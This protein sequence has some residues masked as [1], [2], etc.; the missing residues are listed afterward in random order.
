MR[1]PCACAP[2][3][4]LVSPAA[5]LP[6]SRAPILSECASFAPEHPS[7]R[8]TESSNSR[9][10]PRLFPRIPRLVCA[11]EFYLVEARMREAYATRLGSVHLQG[12]ARRTHV[13][14]SRHLLFTT[15]RSRTVESPGSRGTGY[16]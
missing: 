14:R 5:R 4:R 16:T 12:D 13:K 15:R 6:S 10:L 3:V 1:L 2:V 9:T 11:P 7:K 8:S